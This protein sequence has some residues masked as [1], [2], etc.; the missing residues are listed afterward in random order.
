MVKLGAGGEDVTTDE[1]LICGAGVEN[2]LIGGGHAGTE[3]C[4]GNGGGT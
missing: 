4:D 2:I 1:V 3:V